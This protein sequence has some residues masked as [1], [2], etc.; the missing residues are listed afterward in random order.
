MHEQPPETFKHASPLG[1]EEG[2]E[3]DLIIHGQ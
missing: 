1:K 2:L 3:N